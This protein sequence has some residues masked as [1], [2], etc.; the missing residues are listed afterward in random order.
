MIDSNTLDIL[1][2]L[3][4]LLA[5]YLVGAYFCRKY[6]LPPEDCGNSE[7]GRKC[8]NCERPHLPRGDK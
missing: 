3:A 7:Q 5:M 2:V 6:P 4:F 8:R 1:I